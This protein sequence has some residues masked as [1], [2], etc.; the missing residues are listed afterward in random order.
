MKKK[1]KMVMKD[2]ITIGILT[3][4][5]FAVMMIAGMVVMPFLQFAYIAGSAIGSF[6]WR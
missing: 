4:V 1:D 3:A 6:L 5:M 2:Y